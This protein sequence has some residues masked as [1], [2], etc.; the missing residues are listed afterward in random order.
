M[1]YIQIELWTFIFQYPV[2]LVEN[3]R[4]EFVKEGKSDYKGCTKVKAEDKVKAVVRNTSFAVDSGEVLGLL[5]PN[6]AGKTTTLNM[7]IAE[8]APTKGKV[9][10]MILK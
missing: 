10:T 4:K 6:G 9:K 1:F 3:L 7:I 5:G 2:V 8:L